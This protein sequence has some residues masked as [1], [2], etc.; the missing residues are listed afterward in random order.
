M[1]GALVVALMLWQAPAPPTNL[2]AVPEDVAKPVRFTA[3]DGES[4]TLTVLSVFI[5]GPP[6]EWAYD[7]NYILCP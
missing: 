2:I 4:C 1:L 6:T 3:A 5:Q 7:V